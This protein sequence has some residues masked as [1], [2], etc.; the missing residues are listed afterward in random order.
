MER[1]ERMVLL[2]CEERDGDLWL[3]VKEGGGFNVG[4]AGWDR[5]TLL[6][7]GVK[8]RLKSNE[9]Y[10]ITSLSFFFC[11]EKVKGHVP[12]IL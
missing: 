6:P 7:R 8:E 1:C 2:P 5:H 10:Y 3:H 4:V 9:S 12:E 11:G